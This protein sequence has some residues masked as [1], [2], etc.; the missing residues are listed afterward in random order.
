MDLHGFGHLLLAGTWV[1]LKLA[2]VSLF[3][4]LVLGLLGALA[5]RS[6][7]APLRWLA[8]TYTTLMR[9]LPELLL[10]LIIY[11][12]TTELLLHLFDIYVEVSAFAAG[13]AALSIAFGAYATE[14]FRGALQELP[15]GQIEAAQALGMKPFKIFWLVM[16]PQLWRLALPGL[17]NLFLVLLKDTALVSVIGLNDLMR[18]AYV[19]AGFTKLPFTFYMAAAG[20]YLVLTIIFMQLLRLME[21]RANRGYLEGG[22]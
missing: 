10:V 5:K 4:G 11:F 13:V 14:V 7:L 12:G 6:S 22:R 20:I 15:K 16:L 8:T 9:G 3:F 1:T 19:A 21:Q 18:Q 17:G 2:F